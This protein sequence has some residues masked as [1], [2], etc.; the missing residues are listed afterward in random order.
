M[1][2]YI[3]VMVSE[4]GIFMGSKPFFKTYN[5]LVPCKAEPRNTFAYRSY[6]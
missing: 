4:P 3:Q 5:M 2:P 1:E 6:S